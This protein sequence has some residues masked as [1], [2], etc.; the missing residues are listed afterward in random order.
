MEDNGFGGLAPYGEPVEHTV[1]CRVAM[2]SMTDWHFAPVE[3]GVVNGQTPFVL[4]SFDADLLTGDVLS[5][6]G[7]TYTVGNVTRPQRFGGVVSTQSPL[8]EVTV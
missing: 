7:K 4:A 6:R 5:W 1:Y 2:E 8:T 3:Q